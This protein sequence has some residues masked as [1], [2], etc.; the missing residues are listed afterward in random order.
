MTS[1]FDERRKAILAAARGHREDTAANGKE[2]THVV[3]V[4]RG[5]RDIALLFG[6]DI[7]PLMAVA[8]VVIAAGHADSA[9]LVNDTRG[10]IAPERKLNPL[11]GKP[12]PGEMTD[13][14]L[15]AYV[16]T[17]PFT[18]QRWKQGEM[19]ELAEKGLAEKAGLRDVLI[20][21]Y[22]ARPNVPE[23]GRPWQ[24]ALPYHIERR[25]VIWEFEEDQGQ[26][27][28]GG[29][30]YRAFMQAFRNPDL[31]ET[32]KAHELGKMLTEGMSPEQ[33]QA[34]L[35]A[36]ALKF[37]LARTKPGEVMGMVPMYE[38]DHPDRIAALERSLEPGK[39][40]KDVSNWAR[41][42]RAE[43]N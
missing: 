27:N 9:A 32:I 33:Q 31:L 12:L 13:A 3:T 38:E 26:A 6:Y 11:T 40:Q 15:K 35:D 21:M 10:R 41:R 36:A 14:E 37:G 4:S 34:H 22:F 20:V 24:Y 30:I 5:E 28:M 29:W 1:S 19:Q 25:K 2:M 43:A 16:S 7:Q 42:L 8:E 17:N 23:A 18:G 39:L